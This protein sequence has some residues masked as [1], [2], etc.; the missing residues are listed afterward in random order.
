MKKWP[1]I[2]RISALVLVL[3]M[4]ATSAKFDWNTF[5]IKG[6]A[7]WSTAA[8]DCVQNTGSIY[9][10]ITA[11]GNG[12]GYRKLESLQIQMDV[13]EG[14]TISATPTI[15]RGISSIDA[16][17]SAVSSVTWNSQSTTST[18]GLLTFSS[19]GSTDIYLAEGES[20]VVE[21]SVTVT[22][23]SENTNAYFYTTAATTGQEGETAYCSYAGADLVGIS[24]TVCAMS[25]GASDSS[26][27]L[28]GINHVYLSTSS[29][30]PAEEINLCLNKGQSV[31]VTPTL[32]PAY[33]YRVSIANEAALSAGNVASATVQENGTVTIQ[34]VNPGDA[35]VQVTCGGKTAV[36]HVKVLNAQLTSDSVTYTGSAVKP[37]VKVYN[38]TGAEL[39]EGV[40][41]TVSYSGVD[42]GPATLTIEG[43]GSAYAGYSCDKSYTI[44]PID[45]T[46]ATDLQTL[47]AAGT[48]TIDVSTDT[49]TDGNVSGLVFN[50]DYTVSATRD[51][52]HVTTTT[53]PYILT[54]TGLGNYENSC[55]SF[56]YNVSA[57][58]STGATINLEDVAVLGDIGGQ[59]YTGSAI[60][61]FGTDA[62]P[63][64]VF[65]NANTGATLTGFTYSIRYENNVTCGT[66]TVIVTGTG[67]YTGELR[68]N[69]AINK[70]SLDS[71][72]TNITVD[73]IATQTYTGSNVELATLT[74][75][76]T[77]TGATLVKG[78]DYSVT[79]ANNVSVGT[80]TAIITGINNYKGSR[81]VTFEIAGALSAAEITLEG[82]YVTTSGGDSGYTT[83][84]DGQPV[85]PQ[86]ISVTLGGYT[87]PESGYTVSWSNNTDVGTDNAKP[88]V[89]VT[90]N[91]GTTYA[92]QTATAIFT[93][94]PK[95][96]SSV[97]TTFTP[98][99]TYYTGEAIEPTEVVEAQVYKL[100][101]GSYVKDWNP[102][103]E[104]TDYTISYENNIEVGAAKA[105]ITGTGNYTGTKTVSSAFTIKKYT[106][107]DADIAPI[108]AVDYTGSELTP[109]VTVKNSAGQTISDENY[110]VSYSDNINVGTATVTVTGK[111][112]CSGTAT[113]TFRI[114][115][116]SFIGNIRFTLNGHDYGTP[117]TD[118]VLVTQTPDPMVEEYT[119]RGITATVRLYD[120]TDV[121]SST[122]YS[123]T[124]DN[125][126]NI[127]DTAKVII[128]GKNKYKSETVTL[129]FK[130]TKKSLGNGTT[131]GK[132]ITIDTSDAVNGNIAVRD[133]KAS[134]Q[135]LTE[136]VAGVNDTT[137]AYQ[138]KW[139]EDG[140]Q[141]KATYNS[142]AGLKTATI[143]GLNN[144]DG[145]YTFTYEIGK[146]IASDPEIYLEYSYVGMGRTTISGTSSFNAWDKMH[147]VTSAAVSHMAADEN[148]FTTYYLGDDARPN[149][150]LAYSTGNSGTYTTIDQAAYYDVAYSGGFDKG[151]KGTVTITA[152][153]N[154]T[155]YYG[156]FTFTYGI[157]AF[158]LDK[159]GN[160][161][162]YFEST[163]SYPYTGATIDPY[164]TIKFDTT[165]FASV[166]KYED[167][168]DK[169]TTLTKGTDYTIAPESLSANVQSN[170][171]VGFTFTNPNFTG[172]MTKKA[173]VT[174]AN[175][176][177]IKIGP[178]SSDTDN[179]R[180]L[181]EGTYSTSEN[182]YVYPTTR[183]TV[184]YTGE[185]IEPIGTTWNL[186]FN[187]TK[188]DPTSYTVTYYKGGLD[189]GGNETGLD[190][191]GKP[192]GTAVTP[193]DAGYYFFD[194]ALSSNFGSEHIY[195][196]FEISPKPVSTNTVAFGMDEDEYLYDGTVHKPVAGT[197]FKVYY[198][199]SS[200]NLVEI[201]PSKYTYDCVPVELGDATCK[202]PGKYEIQVTFKAGNN[203]ATDMVAKSY[204]IIGKIVND[205]TTKIEAK[206]DNASAEDTLAENSY[207]ITKTSLTTGDVYTSAFDDKKI[208]LSYGGSRLNYYD[209]ST[210]T[211]SPYFTVTTKNLTTPGAATITVK[212]NSEYFTGSKTYRVYA[213][214]NIADAEITGWSEVET[215]SGVTERVYPYT[216]AEI[217]PTGLVLRYNGVVLEEGTDYSKT[218]AGNYGI[219]QTETITFTGLG[220]YAGTS[221]NQTFKVL[222][223]LSKATIKVTPSESEYTGTAKTTT[224]SSAN[225]KVNVK[226]T[227]PVKTTAG[228]GTMDLVEG[229][230]TG[231]YKL[232]LTN[233]TNV[234]TAY[235]T[236]SS[237]GHETVS[238]GTKQANFEITP[239]DITGDRVNID[240]SGGENLIYNG[241][242]QTLNVVCTADTTTTMVEGTDYTVS[243]SNNKD[244]GTNTATVT[245][246][247]RGNYK[248]TYTER[249]SIKQKPIA[250][251]GVVVLE[252]TEIPYNGGVRVTPEY[253]VT[254]EI[255]G[256]T[257]RLVLGTDYEL[258]EITEAKAVGSTGTVKVKG[259]GNYTGTLTSA[260][261]TVVK[262]DLSSASISS[263][264]SSTEYTGNA[265]DYTSVLKVQIT[266]KNPDGTDAAAKDLI[267][268]TDYTISYNGSGSMINAG[269]YDVVLTGAGTNYTGTTSLQFKINPKELAK[270]QGDAPI[271]VDTDDKYLDKYDLNYTEAWDYTGTDV[272]PGD[273]S[274]FHYWDTSDDHP[275]KTSAAGHYVLQYGTDYDI[276][277]DHNTA[278]ASK[279]DPDAPPTMKIEGRGNYTGTVEA[280]F[281]IGKDLSIGS[282]SLS[283][284]TYTY[285]GASHKPDITVKNGEGKTLTEGTDYTIVWPTDAN[286]AEDTASAGTKTVTVKGAGEYY[287]TLTD[288]YTIK[289]RTPDMDKILV[290][291]NLT[292]DSA[293]GYYYTTY[294]GAAAIGNGVEPGVTVYDTS[295]SSSVPLVEGTDYTVE[296]RNNTSAGSTQ[297]LAKAIITLTGNYVDFP[298][299]YKKTA[300]FVIEPRPISTGSITLSQDDAEWTGSE[301][302]PIETVK[303]DLGN[304]LTQGTDYT[305]SY[306]NNTDVGDATVVITA[307]EGG[308]YT[309]TLTKDFVIFGNLQAESTKITIGKSFYTGN[310]IVPSPEVICGGKTLV[311]SVEDENGGFTDGDFRVTDV[312]SD[313]NYETSATATIEAVDTVHYRGTPVYVDFEIV[314]DTDVLHIA[315]VDD[316][317]VYTGKEIKPELYVKDEAGH[318]IPV[319]TSGAVYVS[320]ADGDACINVGTVTVT[321][322]IATS[323]SES[324][325]ISTTYDII[326]RNINTGSI[327]TL[328]NATYTGAKLYP[329][330]AVVYDG[331]TL[332]T[333]DDGDYDIV[334]VNNVNPGVA[335][336]TLTGKNNFTGERILHFTIQPAKMTGVQ[337]YGISDSQMVVMWNRANHVD[338]Y[339]VTYSTNGST[340]KATT[341][342][343][344]YTISG[345]SS[346]TPYEIK[347]RTYVTVGGTKYYG[348]S[349]TTSGTTFV[350]TPDYLLT[351]PA[352]GQAQLSWSVTSNG[353]S[354][355]SIYR[356]D[357]AD[358]GF[359]R[360]ADVPSTKTSWTN[361]SLKSGKT[362]YYYIQAYQSDGTTITY[363]AKSTIRSITVK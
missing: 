272:R 350:T 294:P 256:S 67:S 38:G 249:F 184:S 213:K 343:T 66:A 72:N 107:T 44:N 264:V 210:S 102:L 308:N 79:Y 88:T 313:N 157:E 336:V 287:G 135:L 68:K 98:T 23:T 251:N 236:I 361:R 215:S 339:E 57:N 317:Y 74:V 11:P 156:N 131:L 149:I 354:G 282:M 279:D 139:G 267:K 316:Q 219:G 209:T 217:K 289:K 203:Y 191:T 84:Y 218:Y 240:I 266:P 120:G 178:S 70:V 125:N 126:V 145:S 31:T 323:S 295:I 319:D 86:V 327:T 346:S 105:V 288:T 314:N 90:G 83:T 181:L 242:K 22:T 6:K 91:A 227:Y 130:I 15:Y 25:F 10:V 136:L 39:T 250:T 27:S 1:M 2:K 73:P 248:G 162:S 94:Q 362:Y 297:N 299:S 270:V 271:T 169:K 206:E 310:Q 301:I 193:K 93:I 71:S 348:L 176:S 232:S 13:M 119:G 3:A 280:T 134:P 349:T 226:V 320:D 92:G 128:T 36:A 26:A 185:E 201:D 172:T 140:A 34:G 204:K 49:V 127:G 276:T 20:A 21:F 54:V 255:G 275:A 17:P 155:A 357:R 113:A 335:D 78:T 121:V 244:V 85:K 245:V 147:Q 220:N 293:K 261:F 237:E 9:Q 268:D 306:E 304:T 329:P 110:T 353:A 108:S 265:I 4:V 122:N 331:T 7:D 235:A 214:G 168:A 189:T 315:G 59:N 165:T 298:L 103:T 363:G 252:E 154:Q 65:K 148:A 208:Y 355:Y 188:M 262:A 100:S 305:V 334:Y 61:P 338:G 273:A 360:I 257:A 62:A 247:G 311:Q 195:G 99:S 340:K 307:K 129:Y 322:P 58:A 142:F 29:I 347:V 260:T 141:D 358:S 51:N 43:A 82:G 104:G 158:N 269:T 167:G 194:I 69:F 233:N 321:L 96:I 198:R 97:R 296:Y 212:G 109:E 164:G 28:S 258:D 302:K 324:T 152:K 48:Y 225:D 32:D 53:I 18:S 60:E 211:Y 159:T 283:E 229:L 221:Q 30:S 177:S 263:A 351:S 345:L 16:I 150:K 35:D 106:I 290:T 231:H 277:Y 175:K 254:D 239:I 200:T 182:K 328:R 166:L 179:I 37:G 171:S 246:T 344:S 341:T 199:E 111:K 303:D 192:T 207:L 285:D 173:S 187:D 170:T 300:T 33:N 14:Q 77:D 56:T 190:G 124:Y 278:S 160:P 101:G 63:A 52:E 87:L 180:T 153:G 75:K 330:V 253:Y 332:S 196:V 76:R 123:V 112:N 41:Y 359:E 163:D 309:G 202:D 186:Y 151:E 55:P 234:G 333:G 337:A 116:R 291:P 228:S 292:Y 352:K 81:D 8:T 205:S 342:S 274:D 146:N 42:A 115:E 46:T 222:L 24:H 216:G 137:A 89:T 40:D 50:T 132:N 243:Y 230:T 143:E 312:D 281:T 5:S 224:A 318:E 19:A 259:K 284:N 47:F 183:K 12:D 356:S 325:E 223:D 286:G 138:I 161:A 238:Y 64:A 174:A 114:N 326:P 197:D 45:L 133:S 241:A 144:Y 95:S 117:T 80:A 118:S